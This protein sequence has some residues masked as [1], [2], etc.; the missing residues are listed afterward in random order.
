VAITEN[1]VSRF[2]ECSDL[3]GMAIDNTSEANSTLLIALKVAEAMSKIEKV[4]ELED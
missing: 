2:K 3:I 4:T 1:D